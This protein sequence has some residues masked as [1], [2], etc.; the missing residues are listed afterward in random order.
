MLWAT[1]F[2]RVFHAM[3]CQA[4]AARAFARM[5]DLLAGA[6]AYAEVHE[7]LAALR[8]RYTLAVLSNADEDHL[9]T[10]LSRNG[11]NFATVI[12]SENAAS[13]K[14]YPRI[15]HSAGERLGLEPAQMLYVGD[16]PIA[17]VLGARSAGLPVAWLNRAGADRPEQMPVPELEIRDLLGLLPVLLPG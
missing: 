4:D 3:E 10:C 5:D 16:S 14:P 11:L 2:E 6:A 12:S 17:D 7:A 13:Y 15:F 1:Q 9:Q 8:G